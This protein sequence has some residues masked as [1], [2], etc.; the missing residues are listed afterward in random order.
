MPLLDK[1]QLRERVE[2]L[3][4]IERGSASAGERQAAE[5]IVAELR[6]LGVQ[7][8][9]EEERVHGTYWWPLGILTAIGALGGLCAQPPARRGGG[10]AR[11]RR[12]L[13]RPPPQ[14]ALAPPAPLPQRTAVNVVAELG[15][16]GSAEHTVLL[17]AHHDAAHSGL[18]FHPEIPRAVGRR[19]PKLLERSNTTPPTMWG[20]VGGPALVALGSLVGGRLGRAAA[21]VRRRDLGRLRRRDGGHRPAP[22]RARRERQRDRRRGAALACARV[23]AK[24]PPAGVARDP[25]LD[26]RGVDARGDGGVRAPPLRRAADPTAR[27]SSTSTRSGRRTCCCWRARGCSASASTRRT[28]WR[29]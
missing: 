22:R 9:L 8:R 17:I 18:V 25:A 13:G 24:K 15:R 2:R 6:S 11:R 19:F 5:L 12:R 16:R 21:P 10:R 20:A 1:A 28:S 26:L 4:A 3:A 29:W 27:T 7:A 14:P 23:R